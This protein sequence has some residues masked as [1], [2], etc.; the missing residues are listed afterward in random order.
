MHN[1]MT[2]SPD[3]LNTIL[4]YVDPK[5][6]IKFFKS[7]SLNFETPFT[8]NAYDE[9]K[10]GLLIKNAN[11]IFNMFPNIKL[12]AIN[13]YKINI[14]LSNFNL[15]NLKILKLKTVSTTD[16]FNKIPNIITLSIENM[17]IYDLKFLSN[18]KKLQNISLEYC[19]ITFKNNYTD[20]D[21]DYD[22][23]DFSVLE[24]LDIRSILF[25]NEQMHCCLKGIKNFKTLETLTI[26]T[27]YPCFSET[28]FDNLQS[29]TQLKNLKMHYSYYSSRTYLWFTNYITTFQLNNLKYLDIVVSSMWELIIIKKCKNLQKLIITKKINSD[30]ITPFVD[31]SSLNECTNLRYIDIS[32]CNNLKHINLYNLNKL[33]IIVINDEQVKNI[34]I[35][36]NVK[37]IQHSHTS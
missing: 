32:K 2:F 26:T 10:N 21:Y 36:N 1:I 30:Y 14:T 18:C 6:L 9:H 3:V 29:C 5:Q 22:Y 8:Y 34:Q 4:Q 33:R 15:T 16:I 23:F 24:H 13:L 19:D 28:F 12:S 7:Q 20:Y 17:N 27:A 37:I 25:T 11:K 35:N 31:I